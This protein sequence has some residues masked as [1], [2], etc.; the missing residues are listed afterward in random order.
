MIGSISGCFPIDHY[1]NYLDELLIQG[2]SPAAL[3]V[4]DFPQIAIKLS[5]H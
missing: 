3:D 2:G 1:H 4:G 5:A